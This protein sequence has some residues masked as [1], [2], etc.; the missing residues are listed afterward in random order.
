MNEIQIF[1]HEAFGKLRIVDNVGEPWFVARDVALALGYAEPHKAVSRHCKK[2]NDFNR[3]DSSRTPSAKIIPESD[4]YR[5]IMRS[6]LPSA[7]QFQDWVVEEVLPSIRK[8]GGY[9]VEEKVKEALANPDV[10]IELL[11]RLKFE[12]EKR[13]LAERQREE[14]IRTKAWIGNRRE[15]TSMATASVAVR[16]ATVAEERA[17]VAE[18]AIGFGETWKQVKAI[19][20]LK[21]C[22]AL[23]LVAYQQIGKKLKQMSVVDGFDVKLVPSAEYPDGVKAYHIDVVARFKAMLDADPKMMQ[24]YRKA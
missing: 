23:N 19:P 12:N 21:D 2:A 9:I 6:T 11:T 15:A 8:H 24:K 13:Q 14:A 18:D 5:L 22:F 17:A 7:E 20:W 10:L 1:E 4:V 3:D 16:R